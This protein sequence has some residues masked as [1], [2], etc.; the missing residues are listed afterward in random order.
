MPD[1][2]FKPFKQQDIAW[3]L[4]ENRTT[5]HVLYGGSISGGKTYFACMWLLI[6]CLRY[7]GTRWMMARA[8]L[9]TLRRTTLATFMKIV[10]DFKMQDQIKLNNQT[11]IIKFSNGSEIYLY[12]LYLYPSDPNYER[13]GGVEITGAVIDELS[14]IE[15]KAFQIVSS[16]IRYKLTEYNLIPKILC[17]SNPNKGWVYSYFYKPWKDG[18]ESKKVK[19]VQA[20]TSDNIYNNE[21][22]VESLNSLDFHLR[23]RLL[24]G[25]WDFND[26]DYQLFNYDA[27]Q[28]AFYNDQI[29]KLGETYISADIANTGS[30]RTVIC[31]WKGWSCIKMDILSKQDTVS[32]ANRIKELKNLYNV[33]INNI[34]IDSSGL[35][36]GVSDILKGSVKYIGGEKALNNEKYRNIKSQLY[37][38][39]AEKVNSNLVCF[40]FDYDEKLIFEFL[41]VRKDFKND[42]FSIETKDKIKQSLGYSPDMADALYLRA[43]FDIKVGG[44][45]KIRFI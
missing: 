26:S 43:Y 10:S 8:R 22:Y 36:V 15:W 11:N 2:T 23:A 12:D 34:I 25:D 5:Q 32:V 20:L 29:D 14:E 41:A 45:T 42:L 31:I 44:T 19:F 16:R 13:L 6:N 18:I 24:N 7:S 30:D 33:K 17:C 40:N 1:I 37:F 4:L 38:R 27:L 9:S 39:F 3:K 35:G 21:V 28:N